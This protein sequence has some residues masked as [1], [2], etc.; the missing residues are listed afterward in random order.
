MAPLTGAAGDGRM[1]DASASKAPRVLFIDDDA[2]CRRHFEVLCGSRHIV[3]D[4]AASADEAIGLARRHQY[5]VIVS[6]LMMPR[7][8]GLA[9]IQRIKP[10]QNDARFLV[11]TGLEPTQARGMLRGGQVD[12]VLW[13]P[14]EVGSL[15]AV[16]EHLVSRPEK[17][18]T[19]EPTA[20]VEVGGTILIIDDSP[21]DA[22]RLTTLLHAGIGKDVSIHVV[23]SFADAVAYI[24]S[25]A[26]RPAIV[27]LDLHL[28]DTD[29]LKAVARLSDLGLEAPVIVL[30]DSHDEAIAVQAVQAGAQDYLVREF[31]DERRL[32]RTIRQAAYRSDSNQKLTRVALYDQLTGA[33]N[34]VLFERRLEQAMLAARAQSTKMAVVFADLDRFKGIN[35]QFGHDV[36]DSLLSAFA[37]RLGDCLQA[38]D[39]LCRLGGDEFAVLSAR[40]QSRAEGDE[41]VEALR[42]AMRAP[43]E[44]S[45]HVLLCSASLGYA[46]F[47][48]D[49][50]SEKELL[51]SA[52]V[53]MYQAKG[54]KRRG[55]ATADS[56][57]A[58]ERMRMADA[59]RPAL[60]RNELVLHYQPIVQLST[61]QP[62]GIE[63]LL[64]WQRAHDRL[65]YPAAFLSVLDESGMII[66]V[67]RWLLKEACREVTRFR[68]LTGNN[69]CLSVNC[70]ATQI[71]DRSFVRDVLETLAQRNADPTHLQI[72]ISE[73]ALAARSEAISESLRELRAAGVRTCLD[74][75]GSGTSS[76]T[77]L[78][79]AHLCSVKV[80]RTLVAE[81]V[82]SEESQ[83][84]V[85]A[86]VALS[87]GLHLQV[88]AEGVETEQQHDLLRAL[89]CDCAQGILYGAPL[90]SDEL[91]M[92]LPR[93]EGAAV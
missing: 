14:W 82:G 17:T 39:L 62:V 49:G 66:P 80:D 40:V 31:A 13:K 78:R 43:F 63:V 87:R 3:V 32:A 59:L 90:T 25:D 85:A 5:R 69:L 33:A 50:T 61:R 20:V 6:D 29:G 88:I 2:I 10:T 23:S 55:G 26:A 41:L 74:D 21:Y 52:D 27:L 67:G 70:T 34:R 81:L 47:P 71:A 12:G 83:A 51:R 38:S 77:E 86:I 46:L 58:S 53:A 30:G 65:L 72:E 11:T 18:P 91:C 9:V 36:G 89:G 7:L 75:F 16:L 35:D 22:H 42:E 48:D 15:L 19:L 64:R 1:W 28:P 84:T 37:M 79:R 24:T 57:D 44:L 68:A 73:P 45:G 92:Q 8:D 4:L 60:E 93:A 56:D 54:R 76:L